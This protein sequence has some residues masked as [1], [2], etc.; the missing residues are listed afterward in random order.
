MGGM[1][2]RE[3]I[4]EDSSV[5]QVLAFVRE[6]IINGAFPPQSK[7]LP[8]VIAE[9][10]G[11]SFIPVREALRVLESEGFVTFVHNRGAWVTP[12]SMDDLD[13][14]YT[15]RIELECETLR[16]AAPF[17][18]AEIRRLERLLTLAD[19]ASRRG[20]RATVIELNRELHLT[21]YGKANSPRRIKLIEQLWLHSARYQ[22]LSLLY[23]HDAADAEH[24]LIIEGLARGDHKAAARALKVHLETT[25]RLIRE[26]I[27][28]SRSAS[29]PHPAAH[30]LDA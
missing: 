21:I 29:S 2:Q 14:L 10:C 13:D 7:L 3:S 25:V 5:E 17:S 19:K 6:G 28:A 20:D 18:A 22:R 15:I 12:L 24:R 16:R 30:L 11:T 26:G 1:E 4:T 9:A 8:K 23:R 27:E